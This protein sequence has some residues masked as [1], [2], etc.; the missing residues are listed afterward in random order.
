MTLDELD[1]T[2]P[3]GF[4]D[5]EIFSYE[6]DFVTGIAKFYLNILVGGPDDL[7]GS[8]RSTKKQLLSSAVYV[9]CQLIRLLRRTLSFPMENLSV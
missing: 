2:L 7:E 5:A 8:V 9:S 4:H 6:F 3:N 1:H